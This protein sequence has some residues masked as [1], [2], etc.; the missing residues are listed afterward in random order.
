METVDRRRLE[1]DL[2]QSVNGEV[3]FSEG[4]QA[5]Y[6][7]DASNYRRIP[8]GAV[9]PRDERDVI[10]TIGICRAYG[11]PIL[12]RGGGTSLAGQ[13]CNT[14]VVLDFSKYMNRVIELDA[15]RKTARVQ[16]GLILDD[17]R[18]AAEKYGLTFGPDPATHNRCTL[19]G[20]IG[21]NSCGVHSVMSGVTADN[22]DELDI[23]TYHGLRLRVGQTSDD[24]LK[25]IIHAGGPRGEIYARL[26]R[27]RDR[28]ASLIRERY[29]NIPRRV[30]GYNLDQL[31]P[32][33]GFNVARALVGSEGTCVTVV[34]ATT[35]L[36]ASPPHRVLVVLGYPD[37]YQAADHVPE[38]LQSQPIGLEG[39]DH[40]LIDGMRRMGL[41]AQDVSLLPQG[42]GWLLVEFGGD[43][44]ED[45]AAHART[46]IESLHGQSNAPSAK[47]LQDPADMAKIWTV[48]EAAL[49]ATAHVPGMPV[50]WPGWEDSAV[51]P[52]RLGGY[53]RDL[54]SLLNRYDYNA[55]YYGHFGQGC[56][57]MRVDFDLVT[58][59][60]IDDYRRFVGE[61]ADL[62]LS[63]SGSL[64]G[65][66]GDGQ[67]RSELLP[68]M[69]GEDLIRAFE[70]FKAI[71]DPTNKMN[72]GKIVAPNLI[73]S[74]LR[75][76]T[77]YN[78][79]EPRTHF[80][81]VDDEGSFAKATL[82]CVGVG[83]CRRTDGGVMCPSFMVT[84]E[85]KH[86]TRGRARLLFEMLEG[87]EIAHGW[88]DEN[89]KD[90]LDLCLACKG[91]KG[92]CPVS[93]DMA[94]YKAE[95]L[96]HYY[97]HRIRPRSAYAMGLIMYW[98]RIAA[99]MPSLVNLLLHSPGSA[100][101]AK[102]VGGVAPERRMPEF[103]HQTFRAWFQ[104]RP[105]RNIGGPLVMLWPDTFNNHFHPQTAQAAV[106]VLESGGYQVVIPDQWLC[107]GRPFYD[108]G[109]LDLAEHS[110]RRILDALRPSIEAGIPLVG[111]EPSCVSVF[112]DDMKNL[113]PHDEDAKRL[114]RQTFLLSEFVM[115]HSDQ[116]DLPRLERKAIV[117]GHCHHH[118]VLKMDAECAIL[119][120]LGL[121]YELLD[122]GCCGMAGAFGFERGDH[123]DVAIKAGER[124]LL[125]KVRSTDDKTLV[126][127]DG[128]SCREQIAQGTNRRA[129]H[130]AEVIQLA[131]R[132][133]PDGPASGCPEDAYEENYGPSR[134]A[135]VVALAAGV[136]VLA[137]GVVGLVTRIRR[138][139]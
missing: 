114:Y 69:F 108:F 103:A 63:Y 124:V 25:A 135:K 28:Y 98:A 56:I 111:L 101:L 113:L 116:F 17:L 121:D 90:A 83:A 73:T 118:S 27:L 48:R 93:V 52:E 10:E 109:M 84:R 55:A 23:V 107:C 24:E 95:F 45:A 130:L 11:V 100:S 80:K 79:P 110:L 61:A 112:R 75:L 36:V 59:Q 37:A 12:A 21:N 86:S 92:D 129:L 32:E 19:G 44:E 26:G 62:V 127:A 91:C 82:R 14:A 20:M 85:E 136:A 71:W 29:P 99:R 89:V 46:L 31:L 54:R 68:K 117:H 18:S 34:E 6:S 126:I 42:Q 70:E 123:Y 41:D 133:G 128:F 35:R 53:L 132:Q 57:H 3:R 13:T 77:D 104:A 9:L 122:S 76:G 49:A 39:F 134:E 96:S 102:F 33:H 1:S 65:E 64:S 87:D 67:S 106:E 81:F 72:P 4:D 105:P 15:E 8:I 30:S 137:T 50:A 119:D 78:P 16:P 125:P 5:I 58:Q 43:S 138:T 131:M 7:T 120:R 94:T 40:Q 139:A 38:L 88:R 22:I 2:R 47:L 51:P 66:H 60:G 74:D 115:E 97:G